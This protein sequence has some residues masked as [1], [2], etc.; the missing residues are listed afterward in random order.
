MDDYYDIL[1]V[2]RNAPYAEIDRAL[3]DQLRRWQQ[4]TAS[5]DLARRQEAER[6]LRQLAQARATLLDAAARRRYDRALVAAG[7]PEPSAAPRRGRSDNLPESVPP[8]EWVETTP[9]PARYEP[10]AH[11][12]GYPYG[13]GP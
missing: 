5:A 11:R 7:P 3:R 4:R 8:H 1:G 9:E 10:P 12:L 6:R 2:A 13:Y